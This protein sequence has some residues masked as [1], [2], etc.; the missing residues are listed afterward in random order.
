MKNKIKLPL[1]A[2]F[3]AVLFMCAGINAQTVSGGKCG[4]NVEWSFDG[5]TGVLT[6][7]G[8]GDMYDYGYSLNGTFNAPP[9]DGLPRT[10][11]IVGDG[12]TSVGNYAFC[13]MNGSGGSIR[14]ELP[15]SIKRIG[16]CSFADT[17]FESFEIPEGTELIDIAAF[18]YCNIGEI[19]FPKS[20][21]RAESQAFSN[22]RVKRVNAEDLAAWCEI[23]FADMSATPLCNEFS[24]KPQNEFYVN[25]ERLTTLT[26]P[27]GIEKINDY[28]FYGCSGLEELVLPEGIKQ[29]GKHS[30]E[31]C[32]GLKKITFG[33]ATEIGDFAFSGCESLTGI[34]VPDGTPSIGESAF[35][36]CA[37]CDELTVP[38][39]VKHIGKNAFSNNGNLTKLRILQGV[40]T[41]GENAFG[42]CP[43]L[44]EIVIPDGVCEI[45]DETFKQCHA[46]KKVTLSG[47]IEKIGVYAF[48][49]C[50]ELTG[51][52]IPEGVRSIGHY[53]F[54]ACERLEKIT[55]PETLETIGAYAFG[56]CSA[57]TK[58]S[59]PKN[60]GKIYT[61]AFCD[62]GNLKTVALS[63]KP[64]KIEDNTFKN[65]TSLENVT[66]PEGVKTIGV[67]AFY[68]CSALK[69]IVLPEGTEHISEGAFEDCGSLV[70]AVLPK[71]VTFIENMTFGGFNESNLSTVY[72]AG[73][74]SD[75]N[76]IY[77]GYGCAP[78][79]AEVVYDFKGT[80]TYCTDGGKVFHIRS[81]GIEKGGEVLLALY[82][83]KKLTDVLHT[84]FDGAMITFA[85]DKAYDTAKVIVWK[86]LESTE[87]VCEAETISASGENNI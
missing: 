59:I 44:A 62:C 60:V 47:K 22:S 2:L 4:E 73:S 48:D 1:I 69:H 25:G 81:G 8:S 39:G 79:Y 11:V 12:I 68:G 20:V 19:T 7:T 34:S 86:N 52:T 38:E 80:K 6:L 61:G 23:E 56:N 83:G 71:S 77:I 24:A 36:N 37:G 58:I 29:V 35:E 74:E 26:I 9:W 32:A 46:L 76:K 31:H 84:P 55:L 70:S 18:T 30:F 21:K 50:R 3:S 14:V 41:I 53:A 13:D 54:N 42:D 5:D 17:D 16:I 27:D 64:E 66:I 63:G 65:C 72:Y 51:I 82:D 49:D 10:E 40:E 85:T 87:P 33:G 67:W 15:G 45:G 28:S 57:L 43:K 75:W 78:G